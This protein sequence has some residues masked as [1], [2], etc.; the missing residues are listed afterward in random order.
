MGGVFSCVADLAT[1]SAGFAAAFPPD[2]PARQDSTGPRAP[3]PLAAASRRLMQ[4]PQAVTGWRAPDRIPGGPPARA[5]VL[6]LRAV[7]RRGPGARPGREPQR[8]LPG[9]RVEHA[10]APGDR[11]RRHRARQRHLL[12][13]ARPG[14]AGAQGAAYPLGGLPRALAPVPAASAA[15]AASAASAGGAGGPWPETLAAPDAVNR[16]LQDWDDAAADALFTRE[17]GTRPALPGAASPTWRCSGH[18]SARS[19]STRAGRRSPTPRRTAAGG[20]RASAARSR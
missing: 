2:G 1:W 14:R 12:A 10:L 8:R 18:G 15:R 19:T 16:L 20:W 13:H 7:R 3:H 5:V 9:L 6:R 4:L 11:P 17:R